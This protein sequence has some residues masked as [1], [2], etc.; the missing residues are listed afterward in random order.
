MTLI[1]QIDRGRIAHGAALILTPQSV[2]DSTPFSGNLSRA[3]LEEAMS[4]S[5]ICARGAMASLAAVLA[6][7]VTA[8][9]PASAQ[10]KKPNIVMLMTD[11]TGWGDFGAYAGG[12]KAFGHPTPT[13]IASP[14]KV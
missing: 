10:D 11:D 4:K 5:V 2:Q 6:L 1:V 7:G 3:S 8:A 14:R 9:G 13:L 12:G